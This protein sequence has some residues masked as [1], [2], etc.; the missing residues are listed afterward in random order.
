[1]NRLH[2]DDL[3]ELAK[4]TASELFALMNA[5]VCADGTVSPTREAQIRLSARKA[6]A[7]RAAQKSMRAIH[8]A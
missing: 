6:L 5:P 4:V 1:M 3:K 2:P 8:A 7:D